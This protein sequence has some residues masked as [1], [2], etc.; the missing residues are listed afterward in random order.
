MSKLLIYH[1]RFMESSATKK[2]NLI[3][4]IYLWILELYQQI[5]HNQKKQSLLLRLK[6]IIN[7][8]ESNM[9]ENNLAAINDLEQIAANQ[10][11]YHWLIMNALSNFIRDRT[12]A[13]SQPKG[14]LTVNSS[15]N[16]CQV[17]Q[18]AI[19]VIGN[20]NYNLHLDQAPL[21][22]SYTDL[23]G[24]DLQ[25][26]NLQHTNLYQANLSGV[27]L[28]NANLTGA[29]LTAAN[30]ESANLHCANLSGAIL[31]SANLDK[32]NLTR[33]NLQ[34][35]NLY[36]ASLKDAVLNYVVLQGTNL[37]EAKL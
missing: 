10:P 28:A 37:R 18:A 26:A 29:I 15:I 1:P 8:L 2:Y 23:R 33:A 24:V 22:L 4:K 27:N 36:L 11:E 31:S 35:A 32:A 21:D 9:L 12:R 6:I 5:S 19:S 3:K 30:L 20:R 17:I 14:E 7:Q 25:G 13:P 16:N 34:K